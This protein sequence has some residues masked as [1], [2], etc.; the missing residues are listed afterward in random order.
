[1]PKG[2]PPFRKAS[3]PTSAVAAPRAS[4]FPHLA[5]FAALL[6]ATLFVYW[7]ALQG[8]LL[9]DDENHITRPALLSLHGLSRIWVELGATQQYYPLLHSAFWFEHHLWG[10]SVL[11]YHLINVL[12]H[13]ASA[14][15]VVLI[16]RRLSLPGA[17][18][19]GFVFALHPV[20][21]EAVAWISEQKSTLSAFLCLAAL[22]VYLHFD[23]SRDR[24]SYL[25]AS[26]LF[27]LALLSKTVVAVLP[28]ALLVIF[29]WRRGRLDLR[30]D[31]LPLAPW[32]AAGA[33]AGLFTAWVERTYI[34]AGT[35]EFAFPFA[36]RLL[37]AGHAIWFYAA[38]V[39]W[40]ANLIFNYPRWQFA[41]PSLADYLYPAAALAV[42]AACLVIARRRR[43]PFAVYLL[44][45]GV[46]FP[47]LGFFNVLPF[48]YSF[49]AD[50][51]E[52][53]ATLALIIPLCGWL[54]EQSRRIRTP[55]A[56]TAL[57]IILVLPLA[58]LTARQSGFYKDSETLYRETIARNPAS[59]FA[60]NNLG[61]ILQTQ[62]GR[63]DDAISEFRTTVKLAPDFP[64]GHS[65]LA[66]ALLQSGDP[67][68][69]PEAIAEYQ[70]ALR[71]ESDYAELHSN[72]ADAYARTSGRSSDAIRE[73]KL[74]LQ[75][76]PHLIH[77]H[78]NLGGL[79]AQMPGHMQQ[80]ASEFDA[81]L[82]IDPTLPELHLN[83]GMALAQLPGRMDGAIAEFQ[84]AIRLNPNLAQAHFDLAAAYAQTPGRMQ[85]AVA[86]CQTAL[87]LNPDFEPATELLQE[88]LA[89][90]QPARHGL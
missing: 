62:P 35:P 30:R 11:G 2:R 43:A 46:L 69:L 67:A 8:A 85:D 12:L 55:H 77:A 60:R 29:W 26:A 22:L 13:A 79:Y 6:I 71:W 90:A 27:L 64:Q 33:S 9:W 88:L 72:L 24:R 73:Y 10:D 82:R 18:L 15:L 40:P 25:L 68:R 41:P 16:V 1:M 32:L 3:S 66:G 37:I 58:L 28:A 61:V 57:A 38:N 75:L 65:N 42:G 21:V 52:Y 5:G 54:T 81:A 20:C 51:F 87:R 74:A 63:L 45:V 83:A 49:V 48:R 31:L 86:E 56:A 4:A 19:A 44:F 89:A 7:P 39:I 50:H 34:G 14:M 70:T 47:V 23:D 36:Q 78:A 53:L 17:W 59:W 80:A 76:D 84:A